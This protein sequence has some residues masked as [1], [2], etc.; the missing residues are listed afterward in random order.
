MDIRDLHA[1]GGLLLIGIGLA[2]IYWP[3]A[4]IVVG[5]ML[6]FLA[7]RRPPSL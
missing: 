1:Y 2:F 6:V 3:A 7:L 4:L 5:S